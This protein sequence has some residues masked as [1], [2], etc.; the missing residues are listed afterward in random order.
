MA[1]ECDPEHVIDFALQ[2]IG[3]G[4]DGDAG[5]NRRAVGNLRLDAHPLVAWERIEDPDDIELLFA[6]RIMHRGDVDAVVELLFVAQQTENVGNQRAVNAKVILSKI[7]LRVEAGAVLAL[8]FLYHR[9]GPRHGDGTGG[10]GGSS[11]FRG[12]SGWSSWLRGGG[13]RW[14]SRL[15]RGGGSCG[16]G[17]FRR[18]LLLAFRRR[19]W[20]W[21][22][23][24]FGHSGVYLLSLQKPRN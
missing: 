23:D 7:S 24:F 14:S 10:L 2:P 13:S 19:W 21:R 1:I 11:G 9:R 3:G 20:S 16:C 15:S 4:P 6:L 18:R 5:W 22:F 8:V 17:T 12:R